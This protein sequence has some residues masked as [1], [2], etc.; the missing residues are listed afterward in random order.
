MSYGIVPTQISNGSACRPNEFIKNPWLAA[1][2]A[3]FIVGIAAEK[4]DSEL[5]TPSGDVDRDEV[6]IRKLKL[7]CLHLASN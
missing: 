2:S 5:L 7:P 1:I 6:R 4:R 3:D